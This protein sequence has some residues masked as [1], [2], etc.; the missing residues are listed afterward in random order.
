VV[1]GD[2]RNRA[3]LARAVAGVDTVVS[4][5]QG[6]AGPGGVSP[7]SVDRDGNANLID[8]AAEGGA[9]VVLMSVVGASPDGPMELFRMKHAAEQHLRASDAPWTIVRSTAYLETWIGL[10]ERTARRSGRPVVFGRGD[11]PINFVSAVDV[12]ALLDR[13]LAEGPIPARVLEVGGPQDLTLVGL[14]E[15]V[16]AAAGR[17]KEPTHV[18]RAALRIVAAVTGPFKPDLARQA[19]AALAMDR[20]DMTFDATAIHRSHPDLPSTTV[21]DVLAVHASGPGGP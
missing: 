13:V 21:A 11:N 2:V 8:A 10:L 5:I 19:R 9:A 3:S 1:V 4:A 15:V 6:F 16:Q 12:A 18:P 20:F 7:A 17:T 14:A